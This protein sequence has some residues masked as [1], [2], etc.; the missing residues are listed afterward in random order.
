MFREAAQEER[1]GETE[2]KLLSTEDDQNI[3]Q[4]ISG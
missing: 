4:E 2:P 3:D 1:P